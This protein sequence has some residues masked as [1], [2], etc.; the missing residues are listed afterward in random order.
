M[1]IRCW[2]GRHKFTYLYTGFQPAHISVTQKF[3][4]SSDNP[5]SPKYPIVYLKKRCVRC[6]FEHADDFRVDEASLR[7]ALDVL[8][9]IETRR[10]K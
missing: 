10:V 9:H 4:G 7:K 2:Y 1:S 6:G 3:F 8:E 5:I